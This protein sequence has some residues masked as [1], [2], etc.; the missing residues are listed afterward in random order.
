LRGINRSGLINAPQK[1][2]LANALNGKVAWRYTT[3]APP[4][5]WY[6]PDFDAVGWDEGNGGFGSTSTSGILLN[7]SWTKSD[8]WMRRDFNL[9]A[10]D[11]TGNRSRL[12]LHLFH[13]EDAEI[14]LNGVLAARLTGFITEYDEFEISQVALSA[15][16]PGRNVIAVHCHQTSGGQGIDVGLIISDNG[17]AGQ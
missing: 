15:L 5:N 16:H 11:L 3:E 4:G 9:D 8:I 17:Q 1:I 13:D 12:K 14:Y 2:I 7:T 10:D 6:Q